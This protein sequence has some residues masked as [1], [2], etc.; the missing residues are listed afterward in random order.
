MNTTR[1]LERNKLDKSKS[2][3]YA[4]ISV[5]S[6]QNIGHT[7]CQQGSGINHFKGWPGGFLRIH[8]QSCM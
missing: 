3:C 2:Y 5:A 1:E 6:V 4:P 7:E 8:I